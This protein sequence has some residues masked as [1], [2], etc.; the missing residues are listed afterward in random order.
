MVERADFDRRRSRELLLHVRTAVSR[1][2]IFGGWSRDVTS[3]LRGWA[4]RRTSY[5]SRA[6]IADFTFVGFSLP[7]T[8]GEQITRYFNDIGDPPEETLGKR[9]TVIHLPP[10]PLCLTPCG[11][12]PVK[13]ERPGKGGADTISARP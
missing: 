13:A 9:T 8:L 7:Q 12:G 6:I 4:D 5:V 1:A 10:P 3:R 2:Y 11:C